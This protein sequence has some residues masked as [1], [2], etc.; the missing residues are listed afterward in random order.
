M[1]KVIGLIHTRFSPTGGVE[2]Y[3]NKLVASLL[4]K[5]RLRTALNINKD[6]VVILFIGNGFERK[7]LG[8]LIRAI[9]RLPS[10]L[11]YTLLV[12]GKEKKQ[13]HISAWQLNL[14]V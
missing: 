9:A 4:E 1:D 7:G 5:N 3:I 13:T 10:G 8:H 14:D 11:S 6:D 12:A 2:N